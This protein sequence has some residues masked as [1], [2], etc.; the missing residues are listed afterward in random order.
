MEGK[1]PARHV[2]SCKDSQEINPRCKS[3]RVGC[4]KSNLKIIYTNADC[5]SNKRTDLKLLIDCRL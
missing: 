1:G 4:E 3:T 5:L 2:E